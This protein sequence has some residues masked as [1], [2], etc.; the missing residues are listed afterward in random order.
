MEKTT[1]GALARGVPMLAHDTRS[2]SDEHDCAPERGGI[3]A[4]A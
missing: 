2:R 3:H 1:T 4:A